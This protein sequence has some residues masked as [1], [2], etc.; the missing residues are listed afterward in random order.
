MRQGTFYLKF[1]AQICF[2][3]PVMLSSSVPNMQRLHNYSLQWNILAT[4]ALLAWS[5]LQRIPT[6]SEVPVRLVREYA[7]IGNNSILSSSLH[8]FML[9]SSVLQYFACFDR[10]CIQTFILAVFYYASMQ[11]VWQ[12]RITDFPLTFSNTFSEPCSGCTGLSRFWN[13]SVN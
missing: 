2:S 10:S 11:P 13:L 8:D 7:V 4:M 6:H 12:K 1:D 3:L 9:P 5:A